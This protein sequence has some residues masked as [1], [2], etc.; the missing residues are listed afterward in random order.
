RHRYIYT[1]RMSYDLCKSAG[2]IR[3]LDAVSRFELVALLAALETYLIDQEGEWIQQN[4]LSIYEYA[5]TVSLNKLQAY[6]VSHSNT[7]FKSND[8]ATLPK[9]TLIALLK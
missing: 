3:L 2:W 8:F 5:S 1:G 6:C 7:I 4:V 9:E